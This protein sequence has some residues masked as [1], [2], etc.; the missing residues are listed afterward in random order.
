MAAR[1]RDTDFSPARAMSEDTKD[2]ASDF[3]SV[4]IGQPNPKTN[5]H[6]STTKY[7]ILWFVPRFLF[8]Q[9]QNLVNVFFLIIGIIT[10][11]PGLSS[12][13]KSGTIGPLLFILAVSAVKEIYEDLRRHFSDR[14][15]N[16]RFVRI[17][18]AKG[19]WEDVYWSKLKVGHIVKV[20]NNTFVPADLVL[21]SSSEPAAMAYI[22]TANLDGESNLKIRQGLTV[23]SSYVTEGMIETFAAS[24]SVIRCEPPDCRLYEFTGV[25]DVSKSLVHDES[26]GSVKTENG[27]FSYALSNGHLIPR[28]SKLKNTDWI[29]GVVVYAGKQTK[30]MLNNTR[31]PTK[32]SFIDNMVNY[33]MTMQ[34][35][36]LLLICTSV[37]IMSTHFIH[38]HRAGSWYL[39][40]KPEGK[41]LSARKYFII[42]VL[43]FIALLNG[44]MPISL[45]VTLEMIRIMQAKTIE[46]DVLMYDDRTDTRAL[47]RRSNLNETL[48]QIKYLLCDKT[49]T[50]TENK[51]VFKMCSING[52][53]FGS[54]DSEIFDS[55]EISEELSH[56]GSKHRS[57]IE[58]F[59]TMLAVCHTVVP[60]KHNSANETDKPEK[61]EP[62]NTPTETGGS[63]ELTY[64]ASSPDELALVKIARQLGYIFT[65]RTPESVIIEVGEVKIKYDIL[66]VL[67]FTSDRKR[68]G[69]VVRMGNKRLRIFVKG[70]DSAILPRLSADCDREM[71]VSTL[72]HLRQFA[73][74]GYRTLCLGCRDIT[75]EEYNAWEPAYYAACTAMDNRRAKID[76][77]AELIEKDLFLA[78]VTAIEDKLQFGVPETIARLRESNIKVWI[79]T[80]DKL[81]T[82][83]NIGHS[84]NLI[85]PH[86]STFVLAAKPGESANDMVRR[87][88]SEA[89]VAGGDAALIID[90]ETMQKLVE[91][92]ITY[93][94]VYFALN[95]GCVICCRCTPRQKAAMVRLVRKHI[96]GATAAIGDGA[97][98][99]AMIQAADVGI[100]I[101]GEEGMQASLAADYAIAQFRYLR[102]LLLVHGVLCHVRTKK[103][104]FYSV[105]KNMVL[106]SVLISF[107]YFSGWSDTPALDPI[108]VQVYNL[109]FVALPP[110]SLGVYDLCAPPDTLERD[111]KL[112]ALSQDRMNFSMREHIK[113]LLTSLLHGLVFAG[114]MFGTMRHEQLWSDGHIGGI[115]TYGNVVAFAL[116]LFVNIKAITYADDISALTIFASATSIFVYLIVYYF[117]ALL[118]HVDFI[119]VEPRDDNMDSLW[120]M[121]TT[122]SIPLVILIAVSAPLLIIIVTKVVKNTYKQRRST[123]DK[124]AWQEESK[125]T[126]LERLFQPLTY[127]LSTIKGDKPPK[128]PQPTAQLARSG[129]AFSQEENG[130]VNQA[131][132][133]RAYD[134]RVPKQAGTP[135]DSERSQRYSQ[136]CRLKPQ[137]PDPKVQST[138]SSVDPFDAPDSPIPKAPA[139]KKDD[140]Q[141]QHSPPANE[142][143]NPQQTAQKKPKEKEKE[144]EKTTSVFESVV[145]AKPKTATKTKDGGTDSP[146]GKLKSHPE[147][148]DSPKTSE[149]KSEL[150]S[151][152]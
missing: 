113:N 12:L 148:N 88:S 73:S 68:M 25:L 37:A 123:L 131:D 78:G 46:D 62:S 152:A 79:L 125:V 114:I 58:D 24:G 9:F 151:S 128:E 39:D 35:G 97:N 47:V 4:P 146:K 19:A 130:T 132:L 137:A 150:P 11:F 107:L 103:T 92:G 76:F 138:P 42:Y 34:F 5:N 14:K 140:D 64:H 122:P 10:L 61:P 117:R 74:L 17:L 16:R 87:V 118:M 84:S 29:Y 111:P 104:V 109:L 91:E 1:T 116:T 33:I 49:G 135:V 110:M 102:R 23:T 60:E 126:D 31:T 142:N 98:D 99:V 22:E 15:V 119:N 147:D 63:A 71:V 96:D 26:G 45:Y 81:E 69:V 136:I 83:I 149:K 105:Y 95:V 56:D 38:E 144:K 100:G 67:E 127:L 90:G 89:E 94:F 20:V 82:A 134:S 2:V 141:K 145:D 80:G 93:E 85:K 133:I 65:T 48:G 52:R 3:I 124:V 86:M 53:R 21:L 7:S 66:A 28:G 27:F 121:F 72:N 6:V 70:A 143:S 44:I 139:T 40:Y 112:Y 36:L 55:S 120:I 8:E 13:G 115:Y 30:L 106:A 101:S 75:E 43:S 129:F 77:Q 32:R 18:T 108:Y 54:K 41:I 50:L 51:M 59:L 57:T